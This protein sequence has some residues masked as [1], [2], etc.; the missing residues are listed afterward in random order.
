MNKL[1]I[2]GASGL[3]REVA[4]IAEELGYQEI[5]FIDFSDGI[6]KISKRKIV[7]EDKIKSI[8]EHDIDYVIGIGEGNL[9]AKIFNRFPGLNYINLMHPSVTM[10]KSQGE[11]IKMTKG[12]IFC[13]GSRF[14]NNI[15]I[16]NFN[17]FNLNTTIGH[18]CY[19]ENFVTISPGAN[20]SGNVH[21]ENAAYIGTGSTVLQGKS[22]SEKLII[23]ECSI[24]GAGAV[25][26]KN[27]EKNKI[28][29]GIP[30]K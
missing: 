12:N 24:V 6:E 27:I 28:V 8:Q 22:L 2:F 30:A 7:S 23:G 18:D 14:T 20:I 1:G 3:A 16:G 9:R 10:G 26:T 13:A 15:V 17:L 29:K 4:D 11:K 19:I 5:F 25:V 21:I